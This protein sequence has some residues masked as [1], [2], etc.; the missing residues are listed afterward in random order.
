M[1]TSKK[2]VLAL[3]VSLMM[4]L[5]LGIGLVPSRSVDTA[6]AAD[7]DGRI[8]MVDLLNQILG[9]QQVGEIT[10]LSGLEGAIVKTPSDN[11]ATPPIVVPVQ[12][13][14]AGG[15]GTETVHFAAQTPDQTPWTEPDLWVGDDS[16]VSGPVGSDVGYAGLLDIGAGFYESGL[17]NI[18]K[19]I[20]IYALINASQAKAEISLQYES[21]NAREEAV[22]LTLEQT[23][24]SVDVDDNA[25]PDDLFNEVGPGELWVST[26]SVDGNG[27]TVVA[28]NLDD[29][30]L[31]EKAVG[32]YSVQ[33]GENIQ[34]TA[35]NADALEAEGLLES[36]ES[37]MLVVEVVD[38]LAALLDRV[39]GVDSPLARQG[40]ADDVNGIAPGAALASFVEIS[41]LYTYNSGQN[42]AEIED[43]TGTTLSVGLSLS[44]LNLAGT[45]NVQLWSYPTLVDDLEGVIFLANDPNAQGW[46]LLDP[47]AVVVDPVGGTLE[48][49]IQTLSVFAPYDSGLAISDIV[50]N[51]IPSN[52]AG[53]DVTLVGVFPVSAGLSV[54]QAA[55]AYSVTI[56]GQAAGFRLGPAK[57]DF[58]VTPYDGVN[59]NFMYV[60]APAIPAAGSVDV[61][62]TDLGNPANQITSQ[63]LEVVDVFTV[64]TETREQGSVTATPGGVALS[65]LQSADLPA[66]FPNPA[67]K[68][69]DGD[70]VT[71]TLALVGVT[72]VNWEVNG[73]PAGS[74][75][76]LNV[77]VTQDTTIT[78]VVEPLVGTCTLTVLTQGLGTVDL[79]P[80]GG[81]Y[82]CGTDVTLTAVPQADPEYHFVRWEGDIGGADPEA[83]PII[84]SVDADITVTAVFEEGPPPTPIDLDVD[85]IQGPSGVLSEVWLF[86]GVVARLSGT[87]ITAGTTVTFS[88]S[89]DLGNTDTAT[90]TVFQR[91]AGGPTEFVVPVAPASW[92]AAGQA[93]VMTDI[94]VQNPGGGTDTAT[95]VLTFK[96]YDVAGD[97]VPTTAFVIDP[98]VANAIG[99]WDG[100]TPDNIT[101]ELPALGTGAGN[102]VYGIA[103]TVQI[104]DTKSTTQALGTSAFD[105]LLAADEEG[106]LIPDAY[107]FSMHLY[108]PIEV[109]KSTPPVGSPVFNNASG[110]VDFGRTVDVNGN[111]VQTGAA[112]LT[113]PVTG[114]GLTAG[115]V[116]DGLIMWGVQLNYDYAAEQTVP[117]V[118][119][120]F[121]YQ[122]ML[123]NGEVSPALTDA[124]PDA[125]VINLVDQARLYSLNGFSLR[126]NA[127]FD[128]AVASG[129]RLDTAS[130]TFTAD[131]TDG[132][133]A[134]R[135]VS[136]LGGLAWVDRVAFVGTTAKIGGVVTTFPDGSAD[137]TNEYELRLQSPPSSNGEAGI[138]D[139]VIY[140]KSAPTVEAAR[141]SRVFEYKAAPQF[142]LNLL[143][144]LLGLLIAI[145]GLAAGGDS[146]GG[147]GGPCFIA[148]A[149]YGTP[150]AAEIDVLRDMRDQVFLNSAAGS[151]FVDTYYAFSPA[152]AQFVADSPVLAS[153]IRVALVPVVVISRFVL[154]LPM[155]SAALALMLSGW[156]VAR[157]VRRATR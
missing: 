82:P 36:G 56:G 110:L 146:G 41:L 93:A 69:F 59:Q 119:Q 149:A 73:V 125:T 131:N 11:A 139:L 86:G 103:R 107:D 144:L 71:A 126:Q 111:P 142:N 153:I 1:G 16:Q 128:D 57:Q 80:P 154:A 67:G 4:V 101:L 40:W 148:T 138:V 121:A 32:T 47:D 28:V 124:T 89:D 23:D 145:L 39:D 12:A 130:G 133:N 90:A 118:P 50:P 61:T 33:V 15:D 53:S 120:E 78:A 98:T 84:V 3:L 66:D 65:P 127:V 14:L 76:S 112:L 151:A 10:L 94:L 37:A 156:I 87:G 92:F 141:L 72:L 38:D 123:L 13:V 136:A 134:L 108:G 113:F 58:A 20:L 44:N 26:Q 60:D 147:G 35:P 117:V 42:Y 137:G 155:L 46:R 96:Q 19:T 95:D 135:L 81:S 22:G 51:R 99:V 88:N 25:I 29:T 21:T 31:G 115:D 6:G 18:Q 54:V 64:S 48:A 43:L 116:R 105:A 91:F 62:V 122:S 75:P 97:G 114:S 34:V 52:F 129:I 70:S 140:L 143:L 7:Q 83:N 30:G 45:N 150:M 17:A 85:P 77:T 157:R 49:A 106:D 68:F 5:A 100:T 109:T 152:I 132:G 79:N 24:A 27:R 9:I 55:A 104:P 102:V 2:L 8:D 63:D 74:N